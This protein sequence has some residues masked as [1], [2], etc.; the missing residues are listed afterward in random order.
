MTPGV[1]FL[2]D[3]FIGGF[4]FLSGRLGAVG[5]GGLALRAGR[6]YKLAGTLLAT[7]GVPH[8]YLLGRQRPTSF[9]WGRKVSAGLARYSRG[10]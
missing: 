1:H 7:Y 10:R 9:Q 4:L 8:P 2:E 5:G 3:L 6:S